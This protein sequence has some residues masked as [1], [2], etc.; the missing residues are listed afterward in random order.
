M[1]YSLKKYCLFHRIILCVL[2]PPILAA[3]SFSFV[4]L[5]ISCPVFSSC[6][7]HVGCVRCLSV[8]NASLWIRKTILINVFRHYQYFIFWEHTWPP[9]SISL[10]ISLQFNFH[11]ILQIFCNS[12][13]VASS[14]P[15]ITRYKF[16]LTILL[17]DKVR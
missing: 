9:G 13:L 6:I 4:F 14:N 15:S 11:F 10:S 1:R 17:L 7:Y 5:N 3:S 16:W 12:M 2:N 8:T